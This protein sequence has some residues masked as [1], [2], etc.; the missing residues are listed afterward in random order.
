MFVFGTTLIPLDSKS[1]NEVL[2]Y[3]TPLWLDSI[4][5]PL[6]ELAFVR[7]KQILNLYFNQIDTSVY[8]C[9]L[10]CL[11]SDTLSQLRLQLAENLNKDPFSFRIKRSASGFE[12]KDG[13][14]SLNDLEFANGSIIHV[15]SGNA[16][17]TD[18]VRIKVYGYKENSF[19][20]LAEKVLNKTIKV[21]CLKNELLPLLSIE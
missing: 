14:L 7:A 15:E 20:F 19:H 11:K 4:Q 16:L 1:I 21:G 12:L 17:A 9:S 13:S 10:T 3:S 18:Q 2:I 5:T 8:N 6:L